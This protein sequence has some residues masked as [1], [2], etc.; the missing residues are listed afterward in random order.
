MWRWCPTVVVVVTLI[1]GLAAQDH[2][3]VSL[4]LPSGIASETVHIEYFLTGPFGGYGRF[5]QPESMKTSFD[6]DPFVGG[7]P[8]ENIKVIA[9]LPGCEVATL[10]LTFSGTSV[11]RWLDCFPLGSV[12]FRG[13]VLRTSAAWKQDGEIEI[14]YLA[15]WSHQFYGIAD[16]P[17]T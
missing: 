16:G 10:D 11:E 12:S 7:R 17:V 2:P 3:K 13:E 6:I 1:P 9:Y 15:M 5:V 14:S 4:L 8:A